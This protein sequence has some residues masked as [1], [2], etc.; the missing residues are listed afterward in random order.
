MNK[1]FIMVIA[2]AVLWGTTGTSQYFAPGGISPALIGGLRILVGG[3]VLFT[4]ALI[5]KQY[6]SIQ[7]ILNKY[8]FTGFI[9][10]AL[11]QL[12]FFYGVKMGGVAV[13]TMVGIGSSP[14]FAGIILWLFYGDRVGKNWIIATLLGLL[15][16]FFITFLKGG[17]VKNSLVG[18]LLCLLAGLSYVIY[19]IASKELM[20]SHSPD[21]VMGVIFL[22]GAL[23]LSPFLFS[24]DIFQ[25]F[26]MKGLLV[27]G[28]LGVFATAVA[29][30]LFGR[31]LKIIKISDA[32]TLS[33]AE[34]LTATFLGIFLIGEILSITTIVGIFLIFLSLIIISTSE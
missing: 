14:I 30:L 19:S 24:A 17:Y 26:S 25:I 21:A 3:A 8:Y 33:L 28:H 20:K 11:Y 29:Y 2:A 10:V 7:L 34:P 27:V 23:L 32:S 22:S 6:K 12:S 9:G 13:G 18:I 16:L 1:G 15:G 31:G 4:Y 5:R